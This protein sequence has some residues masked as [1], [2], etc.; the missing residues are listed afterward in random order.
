MAKPQTARRVVST[1][2]AQPAAAE[3]QSATDATIPA[4][5]PDAP[6][7]KDELDEAL[8]AA[9]TADQSAP[10]VLRP[11]NKPTLTP[12]GWIVPREYVQV[13]KVD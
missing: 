7:R 13:R 10:V 8:E 6:R 12:Q 11:D 3:L 4:V 5:A 1:P 2:G 9:R